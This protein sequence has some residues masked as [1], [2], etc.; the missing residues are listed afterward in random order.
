MSPHK[1]SATAPTFNWNKEYGR[2]YYQSP[3]E[4]LIQHGP[5]HVFWD[6]PEKSQVAQHTR[7]WLGAL[8]GPVAYQEEYK[9]VIG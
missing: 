5:A 3:Q 2:N 7:G 4:R 1:R 8:P 6:R 9:D